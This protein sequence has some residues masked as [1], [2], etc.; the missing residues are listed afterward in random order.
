MILRWLAI[1]S[2]VLIIN[3][4]AIVLLHEENPYNE[5]VQSGLPQNVLN[6]IEQKQTL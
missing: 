5:S 3:A 4:V 6:L 1:G 2:L